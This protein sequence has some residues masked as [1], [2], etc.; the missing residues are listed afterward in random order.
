MGPGPWPDP[1]PLVQARC[2][3]LEA[4]IKVSPTVDSER[5]TAKMSQWHRVTMGRAGT[6]EARM[7]FHVWVMH[8]PRSG[9]EKER[10]GNLEHGNTVCKLPSSPGLR[11][12]KTT[13]CYTCGYVGAGR[14]AK[15]PGHCRS[16]DHHLISAVKVDSSPTE[17]PGLQHELCLTA[18]QLRGSLH[19]GKN[20]VV[21][22][23]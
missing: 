19:G 12:H 10:K 13:G 23:S 18:L 4:V 15:E 5:G 9:T 8:T 3:W 17:T 1:G 21:Y 7:F 2:C 11:S 22:L 6:Y 16:A 20:G 14:R